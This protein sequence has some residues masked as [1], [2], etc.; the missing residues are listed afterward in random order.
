MNNN[1]L[2]YKV[3]VWRMREIK[4]IINNNLFNYTLNY[5]YKLNKLFI[6]KLILFNILNNYGIE[7][8]YSSNG[9]PL[10]RYSHNEN[11]KYRYISI[12]HTDNL[13]SIALSSNP[14]GIDIEKINSIKIIRII[15]KFVRC[16]EMLFLNKNFIVKQLHII[17]GIKESLYK[18]FDKGAKS[19]FLYK[20]FS[21]LPVNNRGYTKCAIIT[22]EICHILL[23][24]Y[25]IIHHKYVLVY[26]S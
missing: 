12:S 5:N 3:E 7:I 18:I 2:L 17:W 4:C 14:I 10:L 16:D 25:E 15:Y 13:L 9:R 22:D 21:F 23:A 1:V 20:V 6:N 19:F 8:Y 24:N 26:I 11:I